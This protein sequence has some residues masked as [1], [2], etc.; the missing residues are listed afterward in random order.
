[1]FEIETGRSYGNIMKN[2][3]ARYGGH[4][5]SRLRPVRC[6][7][8]GRHNIVK[9]LIQD[10]GSVKV[11]LVPSE[12]QRLV[13]T[14]ELGCLSHGRADLTYRGNAPWGLNLGKWQV[15]IELGMGQVE[16]GAIC[17]NTMASKHIPL[18]FLVIPGN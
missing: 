3:V 16:R 17:G 11:L 18:A 7:P 9:V 10:N 6:S 12:E 1:M 5:S 14:M 2:D 13:P 4:R 15:G 8:I